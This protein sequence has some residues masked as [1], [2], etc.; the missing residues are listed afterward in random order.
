MGGLSQTSGVCHRRGGSLT[1]VGGLSQTSGVCH[2]CGGYVTDVG[3]L[4]QTSGICHRRQ[5]SVT[6]VGYS[7][8]RKYSVENFGN[9]VNLGFKTT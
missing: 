1:D 8:L 5:G 7:D 4:S 9:F 6:V 3:G 2:R